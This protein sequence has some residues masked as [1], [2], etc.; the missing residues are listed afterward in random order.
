MADYIKWIREQVGHEKIFLNFSVG[1]IRNEKGQVLM[2]RRGD[3]NL[4]DF[5]GG[6]IELGEDFEEALR[7]EIFEETGIRQLSQIEP[8]GTYTWRDFTYPNG[9]V[10]QPIEHWFTCQLDEKVDLSYTDEETLELRWIDLENLDVEL[11]NKNHLK[12]IEDYK[13]KYVHPKII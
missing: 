3:S 2:N 5:I 9:D 1:I 4:W 10:T 13:K 11:F 6:C 8:F 12:V 7:R